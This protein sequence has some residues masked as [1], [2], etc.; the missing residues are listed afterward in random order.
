MSRMSAAVRRNARALWTATVLTLALTVMLGI[1]YPLLITGVGQLVFPWQANGS[2]LRDADGA[3][4]GSA[5]I[6]QSFSDAH[7]HPLPQYFQPRPSAAGTGYAG[8]DS[9]ASNLGPENPR[10]I[11]QI[12]ARKAAIA[13]FDGVPESAVPADAVTASGSG[14]DPHISSAYATIQITR[15]A[16]TRGLTVAAV[17]ALVAAH[18]QPRDLG[19]LGQPVVDVVALNLA[20]DRQRG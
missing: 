8:D 14:L 4:V 11:A 3:P 18:T 2:M 9:G 15:V 5:L 12:R 17:R 7:G 1:G 10:L 20:L 13:A 16:R 6:G 19:Y